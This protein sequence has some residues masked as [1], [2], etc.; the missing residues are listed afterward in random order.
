MVWYSVTREEM[1][2]T[3]VKTEGR[4]MHMVS[5]MVIR[6]TFIKNQDETMVLV[7]RPLS[8]NSHI[9]RFHARMYHVLR[10]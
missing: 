2:N 10:S 5:L 4:D 3:V 9:L 1:V 8:R 7:R 6:S